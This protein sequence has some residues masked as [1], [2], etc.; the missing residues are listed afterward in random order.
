MSKREGAAL[1][2]HG[3]GQRSREM[4]KQRSGRAFPGFPCPLAPLLLVALVVLLNGCTLKPKVEATAPSS[5]AYSLLAGD[6]EPA[7]ASPAQSG[8]EEVGSSTEIKWLYSYDEGLKIA[9]SAHKP[10]LLYFWA[11]WCSWCK[12]MEAEVFPDL[13]VSEI[14]SPKFVPVK[15]DIDQK[16]NAM[17]IAKYMV[18]GTPTFVVVNGQEEVLVGQGG[19]PSGYHLGAME[20]QE[21]LEFLMACSD[22]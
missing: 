21:F 11:T 1:G 4:K 2:K 17:F 9:K 7:I 14:I 18:Q 22:R 19:K 16:E 10:M 15:M 8:S 20:R 12:R 13:K 6:Q 3:D 5:P